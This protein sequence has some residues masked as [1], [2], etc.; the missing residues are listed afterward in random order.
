MTKISSRQ[1]TTKHLSVRIPEILEGYGLDPVYCSYMLE[2]TFGEKIHKQIDGFI[3]FAEDND[4]SIHDI[5]ATL[6]HDL[7]GGLNKDDMMLPRVTEY[8][9]YV[10][11][12]D[13]KITKIIDDEEEEQE[14]TGD[15]TW[16]YWEG[17]EE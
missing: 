6:C 8:A 1:G 13:V 4:L 11:R 12:K 2:R 10:S 16:E 7:N 14:E 9:D 15:T 5:K 3:K 17:E